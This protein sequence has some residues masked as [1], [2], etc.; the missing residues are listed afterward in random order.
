MTVS[1]PACLAEFYDMLGE[2]T[3]VAM[4]SKLSIGCM[5]VI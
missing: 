4:L 3:R 1:I 5:Y 2:A